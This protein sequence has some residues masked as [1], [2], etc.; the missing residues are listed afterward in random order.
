M[1]DLGELH[2]FIGVNVHKNAFGLFLFQQQ[3]ALELLDRAN[4]LNYNP[5]ATP[6]DTRSKLSA[7]D[8]TPFHDP[9]MYRSIAGTLQYLTLT[10]PDLAYA[11]QQICLFMHAPMTSHFALIKQVLCYIS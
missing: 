3:Y 8:E 5:I 10:W 7:S 9:P 2:H 4:M 6:I 11:V 1:S